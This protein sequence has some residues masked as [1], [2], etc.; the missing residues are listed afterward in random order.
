L[1][2]A[3][4]HVVLLHASGDDEADL[5]G[6]AHSHLDSIFLLFKSA[7]DFQVKWALPLRR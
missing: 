2:E 4:E 3:Q 1:D 6:I 5:R 7:G